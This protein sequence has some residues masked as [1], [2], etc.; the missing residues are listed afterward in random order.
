M[1]GNSAMFWNTIATPRSF[2]GRFV[3]SRSPMWISPS[4]GFV[5]PAILSIVVDFPHP[6]GPTKQMNSPWSM[7]RFMS[8]T[9]VTSS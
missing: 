7:S 4:L 6:D 5:S 9:A 3:T 8:S 2:G 1:W